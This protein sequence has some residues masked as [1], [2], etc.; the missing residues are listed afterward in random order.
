MKKR[1]FEEAH[2]PGYHVHIRLSNC[3]LPGGLGDGRGAA[4]D[5]HYHSDTGGGPG[6]STDQVPVKGTLQA[7]P[8]HAARFSRATVS[9]N[10][11]G[12]TSRSRPPKVREAQHGAGHYRNPVGGSGLL[13]FGP[14][15]LFPLL[16][17]ILLSFAASAC[18]AGQQS[19]PSETT[20]AVYEA[21]EEGDLDLLESY[22]SEDMAEGMEGTIGDV[23][24]GTPGM[25]D[26]LARGGAIEEI[27]VEDVEASGDV[28][29]VT[30]F[31][32]YDEAA[33]EE[34][35]AG[36]AF[37]EDNPVTQTLPLI[38]EEGSWKVSADYLRGV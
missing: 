23:I 12:A 17:L 34:R 14:R 33:I 36:D 20:L 25:A 8:G 24:G 9:T 28:A 21:A 32:R 11:R 3:G 29:R 2:Y 31:I 37:G 26:H 38:K 19:T 7:R 22:Y 10:G 16:V 13:A 4:G 35:N 1:S 5:I 15:A 27:R 18:G 6:E 30:V